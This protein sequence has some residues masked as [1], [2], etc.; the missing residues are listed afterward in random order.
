MLNI[1]SDVSACGSSLIKKNMYSLSPIL[2]VGQV[3]HGVKQTRFN[4][5]VI[6]I[7]LSLI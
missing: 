4:N 1:S 2:T 7:N 3:T 5:C 6:Y